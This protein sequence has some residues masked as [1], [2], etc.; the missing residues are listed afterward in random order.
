MDIP[1]RYKNVLSNFRCSGHCLMI[2]KGR[3]INVD[4]NY[5]YCPICQKNGM[6]TIEDEVHFLLICRLY[7]KLRHDLFPLRW[8]LN[9]S[10]QH[11]LNIMSDTN[12]KS[13][14]LL[15]RYLDSAFK[16]RA[17]HVSI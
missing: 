3:R 7:D 2:E 5:R 17:T 13:I 6:N 12:E 10:T 14:M 4:R 8:K 1:Y 11:F 16:L 9:P 15:C